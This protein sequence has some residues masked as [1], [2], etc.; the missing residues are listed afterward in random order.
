[1]A[2]SDRD[3]S[4]ARIDA[5]NIGGITETTVELHSGINVLVGRNATN[6]TS[7]LKALMASLGSATTTL[8]RD[9][10]E[11]TATLSLGGQCHE[12]TLRRRD[13]TVVAEGEPYLDDPEVA[14]LYAFLLEDNEARRAIEA[15]DDLREIIMR[16]VDTAEIEAEIDRLTAERDRID[17]ELGDLE[18]VES[19]LPTLEARRT[20]LTRK[21]ETT[22]SKL[23]E[24]NARIEEAN[25][26][27]TES[28][29][30]NDSF[31][32][33]LSQLRDTRH[34]LEQLRDDLDV[35]RDSLDALRKEKDE[36]TDRLGSLTD[37][38]FEGTDVIADRIA[39]LREHKRELD[40]EVSD[41]QSIIRFNRKMLDALDE[42]LFEAIGDT[43]DTDTRSGERDI[44]DQLLDDPGQTVC[45][46]C[47]SRVGPGAIES[48]VEQLEALK[49]RKLNRRS[50]VESDLEDEKERRERV[51]SKRRT[52]TELR[53]RKARIETE[54][55]QRRARIETL[56]DRR[57]ELLE[58]IERL[59]SE[60]EQLRNDDPNDVLDL[61]KDANRL[62]LEL[63]QLERERDDVESEI[64]EIRTHLADR[65][66][67]QEHRERVQSELIEQRTKI[68]Q[69][70]TDA[71]ET[72]N[73]QMETVLDVLGYDNIERIW[74]ERIV[75]DRPDDGRTTDTTAFELHVV[76][77]GDD[78]VYEDTVAHL[79]ESEREVTGLVFA[80]A[81]YLVHDVHEQV[82]FVLLDSLEAIDSERIA[83]L[84]EYFSQYA[85]FLVVALLPA[86]ARALESPHR[87][88][89]T[90]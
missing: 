40:A 47:G 37:E 8:K 44:T 90:I 7:F 70:E 87:R 9:A 48:T 43:A 46:T 30:R 3:A 23:D 17:D 64:R 38:H 25:V 82:P 22:K 84:L 36:I 41:L 77:S 79:S 11:G 66:Q 33:K 42:E 18:A 78:G 27:V 4:V 34:D 60:V 52:A 55:D 10:T 12:R 71:I 69:L 76:R 72:Y 65:E 58:A 81:G 67:L 32:A 50:D 61:H 51:E 2:T 86:D 74:I 54:T 57:N 20:E 63:E 39:R 59:E 6:R 56:E 16:P 26:S 49:Q 31:E 28:R 75:G 80:L 35:E 62:E 21:I 13:G 14:D 5:R 68:E 45:W 88:I 29:E 1:M 73:E 19:K 15:G 83:R 24:V 53:D 89:E 85:E